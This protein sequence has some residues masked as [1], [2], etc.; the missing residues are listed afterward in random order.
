MG[1]GRK[2]PETNQGKGNTGLA[3]TEV[4]GKTIMSISGFQPV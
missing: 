1:T 3:L 4:G 2:L